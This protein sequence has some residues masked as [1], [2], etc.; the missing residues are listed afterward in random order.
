MVQTIQ[1]QRRNEAKPPTRPSR[2][3]R[4]QGGEL[5]DELREE[6]RAMIARR[7]SLYLELEK[8]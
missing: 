7:A 4:E 3:V 6:L 5:T 1:P 2:P 8:H